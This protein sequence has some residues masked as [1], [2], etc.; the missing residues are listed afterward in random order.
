[1]KNIERMKPGKDNREDRVNFIKYWANYIKTHDD[2][3]WG[4]QLAFLID[5]QI[6]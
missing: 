5:S 6:E 1:M 4:E 3:D 2:E